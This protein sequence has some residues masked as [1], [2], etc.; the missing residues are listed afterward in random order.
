MVTSIVQELR[1]S[2]DMTSLPPAFEIQASMTG[3]VLIVKVAGEVD[4]AQCPELAN[5]IDGAE[6]STTRVVVD[7]S[8][9]TFLDSSALKTLH[10]C[11][12]DLALREIAL[13]IVSPSDRVVRRVF[14]ITHLVETLGVVDSLDDA[15]A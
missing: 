1:K 3:S 8:A 5:A 12:T 7:L 4:M 2:S 6:D 14:E 15:L 9:V 11:Q 13:R 10:R